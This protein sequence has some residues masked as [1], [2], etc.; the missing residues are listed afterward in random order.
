[1]T[2]VPRY[3]DRARRRPLER[4]EHMDCKEPSVMCWPVPVT[5]EWSDAGCGSNSNL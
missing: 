2:I 5:I 3:N 1:L 4:S